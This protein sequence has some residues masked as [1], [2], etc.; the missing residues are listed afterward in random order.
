[1]FSI[2]RFS[3]SD[4]SFFHAETHS[5]EIVQLAKSHSKKMVQQHYGIEDFENELSYADQYF[6]NYHFQYGRQRSVAIAVDQLFL[7]MKGKAGLPAIQYYLSHMAENW[8]PT[9]QDPTPAGS[10][11]KFEVILSGSG[12]SGGAEPKLIQ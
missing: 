7:Q 12:N 11:G 4:L 3:Q 2:Q 5:S 6:F 8:K 1:M 9:P 10:S